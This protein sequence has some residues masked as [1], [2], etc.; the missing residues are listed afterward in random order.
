MDPI[1]GSY[2]KSLQV[3]IESP[4]GLTWDGDYLWVVDLFTLKIYQIDTKNEIIRSNVNVPGEAP[5]GLTWDGTSLWLSDFSEHKIYRIDPNDGRVILEYKNPTQ[6]HIPSG[7]AWD[8]DSLWISDLSTSYVLKMNSINNQVSDYYYSP[9]YYPSDMTWAMNHLWIL[10]FNVNKIYK[11]SPGEQAYKVE[12]LS[13]PTWVWPVA[14]I[15][16]LPLLL[17]IISNRKPKHPSIEKKKDS[18]DITRPFQKLMLP[19]MLKITAMLGSIYTSFELFR[20]IYNV[21]ILNTPIISGTQPFWIYRFEMILCIF[22]LLYW[23][24][25]LIQSTYSLLKIKS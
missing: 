8:G 3:E 12:P 18:N 20:L 17:S 4:W 9:N 1:S 2:V 10:D 25:K 24:Y 13:I 5:T 21:T 19:D 7:L 23:I 15:V 14:L 16:L 22:T 6:T 11:T